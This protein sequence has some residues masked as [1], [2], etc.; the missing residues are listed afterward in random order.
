MVFR[1]DKR[2]R[3]IFY[4]K[5]IETTEGIALLFSHEELVPLIGEG[6]E[7][8]VDGTFKTVPR[9]FQQLLAVHVSKYGMVRYLLVELYIRNVSIAQV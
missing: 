7:I 2:G 4:Q 5:M 8:H 3:G 9:M 6:S 1:F